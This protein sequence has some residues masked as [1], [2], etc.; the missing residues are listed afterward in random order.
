MLS[1]STIPLRVGL[2]VGA[3]TALLSFAELAF[4]LISWFRG[5]TLPGWASILGL[6]AFLFGV[7]FILLGIQGQYILRLYEQVRSRPSFIIER[8]IRQ[9]KP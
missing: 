4:V 5:K 2:T 3:I 6:V 9:Q 7:L 8:I 1:F